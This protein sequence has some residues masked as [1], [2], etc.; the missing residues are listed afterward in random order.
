MNHFENIKCL[1]E[2]RDSMFLI[3]VFCFGLVIACVKI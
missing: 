3:Y 1:Y 2:I